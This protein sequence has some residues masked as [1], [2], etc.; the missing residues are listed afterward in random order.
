[1]ANTMKGQSL[2]VW[3]LYDAVSVLFR[4]M[5]AEID[6]IFRQVQEVFLLVT[7]KFSNSSPIN[8]KLLHAVITLLFYAFAM[9]EEFTTSRTQYIS[10]VERL[11]G[12]MWDHLSKAV[13]EDWIVSY[14]TQTFGD[15]S[16]GRFKKSS[17][18]IK[19]SNQSTAWG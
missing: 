1:M 10:Q 9:V 6:A 15:P 17:E 7:K 13:E 18:D 5:Y 11:T 8:T 14:F 19:A 4:Y 12:K 16:Y 2:K 3:H